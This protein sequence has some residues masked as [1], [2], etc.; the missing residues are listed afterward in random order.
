MPDLV[1][2]ARSQVACRGQPER[3]K[4]SAPSGLLLQ[5][6]TV[7]ALWSSVW[8]RWPADPRDWPPL[9]LPAAASFYGRWE[10]TSRR[11]GTRRHRK[12]AFPPSALQ[13]QKTVTA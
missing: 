2:W 1:K 8:A 9:S 11:Q 5:V 3:S 6:A 4:V 13:S 10:A 12:G 7:A